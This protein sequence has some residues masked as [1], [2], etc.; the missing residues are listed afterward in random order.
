M[1]G[2][3]TGGTSTYAYYYKKSTATSWT[4]LGTEYGSAAT[5]TLTPAATGTYNIMIKVRD[6]SGKIVS[7]SFTLTVS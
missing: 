7:K 5:A 4:I 3:A 1:Y 2:V 6:N